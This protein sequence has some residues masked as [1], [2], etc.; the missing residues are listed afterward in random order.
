MNNFDIKTIVNDRIG[1]E[2]SLCV[3][4]SGLTVCCMKTPYASSH[5]QLAVKYGGAVGN[6]ELDGKIYSPPSGIAHFLEHKM[7]ER[8]DGGDAF[9]LFTG[10][11]ADADAYTMSRLTSY[12]FSCSDN[13]TKSLD[14]LLEMV[15]T[16]HFTPESVAREKR[17]IEQEEKMTRSEPDTVCYYNLLS[18]LYKRHPVRNPIIGTSEDIEKITPDDLYLC[19]R[20]F[21]VPSNMILS[22]AADTELNDVL[23]TVDRRFP[24]PDG[25]YPKAARRVYP[26]ESPRAAH[27]LEREKM[28]IPTPV[29]SLGAKIDCSGCTKEERNERAL[30]LYLASDLLFGDSGELFNAL[31]DDGLLNGSFD[32]DCTYDDTFAFIAVSGESEKPYTVKK[33]VYEL[34]YRVESEGLSASEVET[35]KKLLYSDFIKSLSGSESAAYR[36]LTSQLDG[37][38]MLSFPDR[39][40]AITPADAAEEFARAF[41]AFGGACAFSVIE[42]D[43]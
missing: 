35:E 19:H 29:F 10:Y 17:I 30:A 7:F 18:A 37:V 42:S 25:G 6:F 43:K 27:R 40:N 33:R 2:Y 13:F 41:K 5:A 31:Y 32:I 26:R 11:G 22:I 38:D 1:E 12:I 14:T 36:M 8:P 24:C 9:D 15:T 21:Y 16:P 20:A 39:L 34:V 3:H 4:K 28:S 23:Q